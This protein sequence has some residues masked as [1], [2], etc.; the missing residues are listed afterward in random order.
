MIEL[1]QHPAYSLIEKL[2]KSGSGCNIMISYVIL[3]NDLPYCGVETHKKAA[4]NA[5]HIL[6][7]RFKSEYS[8]KFIIEK[9]KMSA[10]P[11]KLEDLLDSSDDG[12]YRHAFL[13][14]P[15][16]SDLTKEDFIHVNNVLFPNTENIEIY[17]WCSDIDWHSSPPYWENKWSDYFDYGLEWWGAY[18]WT[19]YDKNDNIFIIIAASTTD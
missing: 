1:K 11:Y 9:S 7:N 15:Y 10:A 14:P 2:D 5:M 6:E 17:D 3:Q 12:E 16:G 8:S 18:F 13:E 4:L 19:I